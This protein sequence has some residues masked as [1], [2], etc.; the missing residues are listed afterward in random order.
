[1][2]DNRTIN[3]LY[4]KRH[5]LRMALYQK[6]VDALF[7]A[8]TRD[9][10]ALGWQAAKSL[11][12][13][14]FSFDD[15]PTAKKKFDDIL[16]TF[17]KNLLMVVVNGVNSE[18]E[19]ANEKNDKLA[20]LLFS[21]R[22]TR[23]TAEEKRRFYKNN[24]DALEAFRERKTN[25]LNLSDKVWRYTNQYKTEI[26]NALDCGIRDGVAAARLAP[27]LKQ[28]LQ[29]PDK[30]FRRVRNQHGV[31]HLSKAAAA[32]HPST[33][34]YRSS[35][36]NA[37]RLTRTETNMAYRTADY[38][39]YQQL[40]FVIGIEIHLSNNHTCLGK[41]G[42]PHPFFDICD[43][44][45]GKY[46]KDFK[47]VGWH[48]QCRCFVTSILMND[49]EVDAM[50]AARRAGKPIPKSKNE[51]KDVPDAFKRY[52]T[53]HKDAI[54]RAANKPY[55]CLDN[56]K[57]TGYGEPPKPKIAPIAQRAAARHAARTPEQIE[58][59]KKAWNFRQQ[60]I[61]LADAIRTRLEGIPDVSFDKLNEL[62]RTAQWTELRKECM[63]LNDVRERLNRGFDHIPDA[64]DAARKF[65]IEDTEKASAAIQKTFDRWTWDLRTRS[66]LNF[67]KIKLEHEIKAAEASKNKYPTWELARDA[68]KKRLELVEH[69]IAMLDVKDSIQ[70]PLDILAK[71]NT[72][73][74]KLLLTE[75][76]DKFDNDETDIFIFKMV[77][78]KIEAKAKQIERQKA[79]QAA[80]SNVASNSGSWDDQRTAE[81]VDAYR[82]Q[83]GFSLFNF[84]VDNGVARFGTD[85]TDKLF[86]GTK[87]SATE[88][89]QIKS[90]T[91]GGYIRT[92]N[93]FKING[94][95][96]DVGHKGAHAIT[97]DI[98][99]AD[100]FTPTDKYGAH[101]K[102]DDIKTIK[103]LDKVIAQNSLPFPVMLV[104]NVDYDAI[105]SMLGTSFTA[106][107]TAL[108]MFTEVQAIGSVEMTPDNG[109]MSASLNARENVFSRRFQL[110]IEVPAGYPLLVTDNSHESECVLG[111]R[112]KLRLTHTE[113]VKN[114]YGAELIVL[115]VVVAK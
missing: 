42:K 110:S 14:P 104:R 28:Y 114:K 103:A 47:F 101:L 84:S 95:L 74:C 65:G 85:M 4:N 106:M 71:E 36:K 57:Y 51:V 23:L 32:F 19:L 63:K 18:W 60:T 54:D 76:N 59:I 34:V 91:G 98:D 105:N 20:D 115:H 8:V 94:A 15:Y 88:L 53:E 58:A 82:K 6:K 5:L 62:E 44:L 16:A 75:F 24:E 81:A 2:A 22:A 68:Y 46:P 72:D 26:E 66:S 102:D 40:D 38:T 50:R 27:T 69:R 37:L 56:Y 97:G 112:T 73:A 109:Y 96:R 64:W 108:Q 80:S 33:G 107:D 21:S 11:G 31:L 111:R 43:E 86:R 30:L 61:T 48:P 9:V 90:H 3:Q 87:V 52:L 17:K 39:R 1:M 100:I 113:M 35:Y 79:Q 77:A 7:D 41:D 89:Y 29:Y 78:S 13:K 83:L 45:A 12:K 99:K 67:L 93:S 25:G 70:K 92:S 55:W 49:D 10:A